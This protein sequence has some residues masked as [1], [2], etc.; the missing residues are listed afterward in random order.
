MCHNTEKTP[1]GGVLLAWGIAIAGYLPWL[2][3]LVSTFERVGDGYWIEEVPSFKESFGFFFYTIGDRTSIVV[4]LA[5]VLFVITIAIRKK[6]W[7]QTL[8]WIVIG[9]SAAVFTV[10]VGTFVSYLYRPVY[11][12]RYLY[13]VSGVLWLSLSVLLGYSDI[14]ISLSTRNES[15]N[16]ILLQIKLLP[17]LVAFGFV[18]LSAKAD[19]SWFV[20][21]KNDDVRQAQ[22]YAAMDND[23]NSLTASTNESLIFFTNDKLFDWTISDRCY[24]GATHKMVAIDELE[25]DDARINYLVWDSELN[26]EDI[27]MVS[28][29]GMK[30]HEVISEGNLGTCRVNIYR[31]EKK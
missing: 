6:S 25:Y 18:V 13:P 10:A 30:V 31:I 14:W 17:L 2:F 7:D 20:S 27:E 26:P 29:R 3:S 11:V 4:E 1:Y 12:V 21:V 5:M 8:L 9:I 28:K 22:T 16:N 15:S 19:F 23:L 24:P